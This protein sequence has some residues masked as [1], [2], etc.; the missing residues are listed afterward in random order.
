MDFFCRYFF[1]GLI[2]TDRNGKVRVRGIHWNSGNIFNSGAEVSVFY[3]NYWSGRHIIKTLTFPIK[4]KI[5]HW[6]V[7]FVVFLCIYFWDRHSKGRNEKHRT[8]IIHTQNVKS[9]R[10]R[11]VQVLIGRETISKPFHC[12]L[13]INIL[14]F[15]NQVMD[16]FLPQSLIIPALMFLLFCVLINTLEIFFFIVFLCC[17]W[18]WWRWWCCLLA[19]FSNEYILT[20]STSDW[21]VSKTSP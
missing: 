3:W 12:Y 21:G 17:C 9:I 18:W 7:R 4:H 16:A 6:N 13:Y 11:L 2:K 20:N 1:V 8:I 14:L 19:A 10:H 5:W 15:H